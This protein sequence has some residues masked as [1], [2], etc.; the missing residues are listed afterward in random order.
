[1]K[2]RLSG[3]ICAQGFVTKT[4]ILLGRTFSVLHPKRRSASVSDHAGMRLA[5]VAVYP[6]P[7]ALQ[8]IA[9]F[10]SSVELFLSLC[11]EF[12]SSW[13]LTW[14]SPALSA[15][16][17]NICQKPHRQKFILEETHKLYTQRRQG[18]AAEDML[19]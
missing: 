3:T 18:Y 8:L 15:P 4:I 6:V 7:G 12:S 19:V 17:N 10:P 2:Q 5:A 16:K 13:F 9:Y 11:S 1:M 14:P